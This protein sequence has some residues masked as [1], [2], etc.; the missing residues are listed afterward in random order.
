MKNR[1][2]FFY[3]ILS[4]CMYASEDLNVSFLRACQNGEIDLVKNSLATLEIDINFFTE[5]NSRF[6][7]I[8][9][10]CFHAQS[11]VAEILLEQGGI[12]L[13][14]TTSSCDSTPLHLLSRQIFFYDE[15]G[16]P[17]IFNNFRNSGLDENW[18]KTKVIGELLLSRSDLDCNAQDKRRRTA[19]YYACE[20]SDRLVK[21]FLKYGVLIDTSVEEN[22]I[23]FSDEI[24]EL[25]TEE[26]EQ[27]TYT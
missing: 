24:R 13:S 11:E 14:I 22:V 6:T 23:E 12:D 3:L 9:L 2:I 21:L 5:N 15:Y 10:A 20:Y 27:R 17:E 19:L 18:K 4:Q 26:K 1:I 8:V 16:F 7:A 25:L